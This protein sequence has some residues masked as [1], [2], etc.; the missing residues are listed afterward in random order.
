ME[1]VLEYVAYVLLAMSVAGLVVVHCLMV[2]VMVWLVKDWKRHRQMT[3]AYYA[4][5]KISVLV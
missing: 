4:T 3:R 5:Q 2:E 1:T